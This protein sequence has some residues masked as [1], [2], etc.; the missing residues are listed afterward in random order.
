MDKLLFTR[1]QEIVNPNVFCGKKVVV[2][3][4]GSG[5]RKWALSLAMAGVSWFVLIDPDKLS[6]EN[7]IRHICGLKDLGC[8]KTEAVKKQILN[9]N[10]HAKVDTHNFDI[11]DD[12]E[13]LKTLIADASLVLAG[14]DSEPARHALNR[15]ALLAKVPVIYATTFHR[16]FC[17]EVFRVIPG[18]GPCYACYAH[19]LERTGVVEQTTK[20][21]DYN[22]PQM[23]EKLS[24]S[25]GLGMD[26]EIISLIAAKISLITLLEGTKYE[27][28]SYPGNYIFWGNRPMENGLVSQYFECRFWHVPRNENCLICQ[29]EKEEWEQS[30][31][32]IIANLVK[33]E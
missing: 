21:I 16:A 12:E 4:V 10:P 29:P 32:D 31:D 1:I 22:D 2:I 3:G 5:G 26:I 28:P 30:Y 15:I 6:I 25:P 11:M 27:M 19:F 24:T 17:G 14:L 8:Y 20:A 7:I 33:D 18:K 9:H 23:D 13:F